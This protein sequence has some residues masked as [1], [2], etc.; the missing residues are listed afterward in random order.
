MNADR[1]V[2]TLLA[3]VIGVAMLT[4]I[5]GRGNT[6]RVLDSAGSAVANMIRAAL[7]A[8]AGLR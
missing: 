7:G 4:T 1:I 8:G 5:L 2:T 3:G 6:P